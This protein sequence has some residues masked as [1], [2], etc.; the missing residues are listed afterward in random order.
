MSCVGND[1]QMP[2]LVVAVFVPLKLPGDGVNFV[3]VGDTVQQRDRG[4]DQM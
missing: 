2:L 3:E 1:V 4:L